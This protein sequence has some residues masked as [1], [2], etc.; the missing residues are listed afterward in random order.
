[1]LE[2]HSQLFVCPVSRKFCKALGVVND[3]VFSIIVIV[4]ILSTLVTPP[5]LAWLLRRSPAPAPQ[6][7][8]A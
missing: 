6:T 8:L 4:V 3:E 5:M 2:S 7:E 1:M